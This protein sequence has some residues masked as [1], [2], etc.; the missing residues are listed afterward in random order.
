MRWRCIG[1]LLALALLASEPA[2]IAQPARTGRTPADDVSAK[3]ETRQEIITRM[4]RG[5]HAILFLGRGTGDQTI[6]EVFRDTYADSFFLSSDKLIYFPRRASAPATID[7]ARLA[8]SYDSRIQAE[9]D[10]DLQLARFG[11]PRML[12]VICRDAQG[13]FVNKGYVLF[14]DFDRDHIQQKITVF[15]V[16]YRKGPRTWRDAKPIDERGMLPIVANM[17]PAKN[18]PCR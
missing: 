14:D 5:Y 6:C 9:L 4:Q 17:L 11:Q 18:T 3:V 1:W 10:D 2:A 16:Y 7:C 8:S 13:H 15:D 12:M